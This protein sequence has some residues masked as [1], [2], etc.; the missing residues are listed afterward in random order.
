MDA[1]A[2][3]R[4]Q[5]G[6]RPA[7][8]AW[9]RSHLWSSVDIGHLQQ[10]EAASKKV[11]GRYARRVPGSDAGWVR[12]ARSSKLESTPK[13]QPQRKHDDDDPQMH[14]HLLLEHLQQGP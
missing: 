6:Q 9:S 8:R 1:C 2:Q 5:V 3:A 12:N 4:T 13:R 11:T 14:L 10:G 7:H